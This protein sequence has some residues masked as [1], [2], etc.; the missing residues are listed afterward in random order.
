M[1]D[2]GERMRRP[3]STARRPLHA[4]ERPASP[5]ARGQ[6]LP[7]A[8]VYAGCTIEEDDYPTLTI[9]SPAWTS[10]SYVVLRAG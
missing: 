4:G 5:A 9:C 1:A 6:L 10:S 8:P 2:C 7:S 3:G